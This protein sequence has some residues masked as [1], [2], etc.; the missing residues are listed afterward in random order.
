MKTP[1]PKKQRAFTLVELLVVIAIVGILAAL[2]LPALARARE[3]ARRAACQ[4]NL[5]QFA[6]LFSLYASENR[7]FYPPLAPYCS[8]RNDALSSPLFAAPAASALIP[9]Y[10][11][12]IRVVHCPSDSGG[13]PGWRSVARRL[14]KTGDFETWRQDSVAVGDGIAL[15]YFLAAELGHSYFYKGYLATS[16][17]EYYG[18]WAAGTMSPVLSSA[19]IPDVG[20]VRIKDFN[21]DLPLTGAPWPPWV[22]ATA[23]GAAGGDMALRLRVGMARF[24][25]TDID[26]PAASKSSDSD[27]PVLW[28]LFGSSQFSDNEAGILNFNHLPGGA[29]VLYLDGHAEFL[30]FPSRFPVLDTPPLLKD[31]SHY[32][33]G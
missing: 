16:P 22:P 11:V 20:L 6:L 9:E 23:E 21:A 29:N 33:M 32:G 4:G 13:D 5:K 3:S 25:I 2:A 18:V 24:L 14:P 19:L 12:D 17:E 15:D 31:F 10:L 7:G 30:P 27:V 1:F 28:D 26:N 8:V